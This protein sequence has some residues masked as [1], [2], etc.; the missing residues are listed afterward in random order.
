MQPSGPIAM[1][2]GDE[3]P[4]S[5]NPASGSGAPDHAW[6]AWRAGEVRGAKGEG[7][8]ASLA[9]ASALRLSR[10]GVLKTEQK[11]PSQSYPSKVA[12]EY[13]PGGTGTSGLISPPHNLMESLN[14]GSCG[15]ALGPMQSMELEGTGM[16]TGHRGAYKW[17]PS[18]E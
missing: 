9:I 13:S 14:K 17:G 2:P 15:I 1:C 4:I 10:T 5:A 6:A 3:P 16:R 8:G 12:W 18:W 11:T 7:G